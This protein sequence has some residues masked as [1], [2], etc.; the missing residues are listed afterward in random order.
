MSAENPAWKNEQTGK[1][2]Q[3]MLQGTIPEAKPQL[4]PQSELGFSFP[5]LSQLIPG[6]DKE[7]TATLESLADEEI[8][9]RKFFDKFLHCPQCQSVNLRPLY[10]CPLCG[11]G[12]IVRGRI[13]EHLLCKHVGT[14]DEFR[15]KGKLVCPKCQQDLRSLGSDYHSLGVLY[16]CRDCAEVFSQ[17]AIKWRCLKCSSI[18]PADK[19]LEVNAYSYSLNEEKRGW[20]AFELKPKSQ[21]I[22]LLQLRGYE[23][24]Q[25]ATMRGGSGAEHSFDIL[26]TRDDNI[27]THYVAI[28]VEVSNKAVGLDRVFNFDNKA[29]DIG[30][31]DKVLITI[32]EA[33][34]E[35]S[36]FAARQRIKLLDP[37]GLEAFLASSMPSQPS[38]KA[39]MEK[40]PFQFKSRSH[41]I[42]YLQSQGYEVKPRTTM[43]GSSGAE[44]EI[45]I[46][47]T[48]DD[49]IVVHNIAIGIEVAE[50]KIGLNQVFDFDDKA[51]DCSIP[52]KVLIAVP[53]LTKEASR[54]A[55]RQRIKV[56]EAK[57]VEPTE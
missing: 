27:V 44:H 52:D 8:L 54:F 36:E 14:E 43:K 2:L 51:Y 46:L 18:T 50:K 38:Q 41:L 3:A 6:T 23:V 25:N 7:I 56:F 39:E 15:I 26:A 37:E 9:K 55:E 34:A 24:K 45:D 22:Q 10:H 42:S 47:A 17:P 11:S 40:K 19:I 33:S 28:G 49:G 21:L 31:H 48:R 13:L 5:L 29:Y 32:P 20:L 1:V 57:E 30:I 16:K 4:N 12:N 53:G 35:A